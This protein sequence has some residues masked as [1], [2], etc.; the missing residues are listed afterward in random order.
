MAGSMS[1]L[2]LSHQRSTHP[3]VTTSLI[4]PRLRRETRA[5]HEAVEQVLD[6]MAV[7]LSPEGYRQ[8]LQ[9]LYGFYAPLEIALQACAYKTHNPENQTGELILSAPIRAELA[10]RLNKTAC[11]RQDLHCLG[12]KTE[13]LPMCSDLPALGTQAEVLGCL[14]VM[15][16]ATLGGRLITQHVRATLGIIFTSGG[17]FFEGYG[18][19]TGEMWQ[20]MRHLLV[21]SAA[22]PQTENA[23]VDNAIATFSKLRGWCESFQK[24]TESRT[25]RSA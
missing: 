16:G 13:A 3:V 21:S 5:E 10:W 8:R 11:L 25:L 17:S 15:E 14:Y 19:K 1:A 2:R 20:A 4:L 12:V 9:Q 18:E 24:Q 23:V 6:L 7:S 22:D